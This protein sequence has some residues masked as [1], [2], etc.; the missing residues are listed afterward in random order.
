[1]IE[2]NH[3]LVVEETSQILLSRVGKQD[4]IN[5]NSHMMSIIREVRN[6]VTANK[7]QAESLQTKY[8]NLD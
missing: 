7:D 5:N 4:F 8:D 3:R 6:T 2:Q 1:M